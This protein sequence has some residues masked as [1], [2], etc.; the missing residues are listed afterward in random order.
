[1]RKTVDMREDDRLWITVYHLYTDGSMYIEG[2]MRPFPQAGDI[3][4]DR[5]GNRFEVVSSM[6]S[7][8]PNK[9]FEATVK[10]MVKK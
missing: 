10:P 4:I 8:D 5:S 6:T 9:N 7:R 3:I 1:M 2:W